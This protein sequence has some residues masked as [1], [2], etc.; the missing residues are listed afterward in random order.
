MVLTHCNFC[1]KDLKIE[2][3][4]NIFDVWCPTC[5]SHWVHVVEVKS[6]KSFLYRYLGNI[7]TGY[8][9]FLWGALFT[10]PWI[11]ILYQFDPY[12]TVSKKILQ[13]G[14][15]GHVMNMLIYLFPIWICVFY[16]EY[17]AEKATSKD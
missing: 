11:W 3:E 8:I 1:N 9:R 2:N 17:K 13:W 10:I 4:E 12:E 15:F 5:G 16:P 14:A 6:I 7:A